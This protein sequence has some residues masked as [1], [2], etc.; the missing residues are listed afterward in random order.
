MERM[1]KKGGISD[2]DAQRKYMLGVTAMANEIAKQD[3]H[4]GSATAE[5]VMAAIL[6][7][8]ASIHIFNTLVTDEIQ[9]LKADLEALRRAVAA[10]DE[11]VSEVVN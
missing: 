10:D 8:M 2:L 9:N 5:H 7:H 3:R 11:P 6:E 4:I 1:A